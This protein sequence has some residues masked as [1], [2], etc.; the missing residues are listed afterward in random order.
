MMSE[1]FQKRCG[2][3]ETRRR[4]DFFKDQSA[5]QRPKHRTPL[6]ALYGSNMG[7][8]EELA[9]RIAADAEENGFAVKVAP[10]DDYAG[11]LPKEGL[12][13]ITSA[14]YNG[15]PPDNAAQFCDWLERGE[16]KIGALSGVT[17]AVFGAA[18]ATGR[19]RFSRAA[20]YRRT[21]GGA[22]REAPV[23]ARRG[24]APR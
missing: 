19:R 6:L 24:D 16:L 11:R 14:S 7:T 10:L 2:D 12:V 4:G 18:I 21:P 5:G 9:R 22:R 23:P 20:L 13:F 15:R 17:Y 3:T 8:A 1:H